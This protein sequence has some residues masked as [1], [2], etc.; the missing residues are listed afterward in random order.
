M[1]CFYKISRAADWKPNFNYCIQIT[2]A[3]T[4]SLTNYK[5]PNTNHLQRY[6]D[7]VPRLNWWLSDIVAVHL[8]IVTLFRSAI[9]ADSHHFWQ[10]SAV[11]VPKSVL[12]VSC[13]KEKC[14][15]KFDHASIRMLFD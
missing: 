2:V 15:R 12:V 6:Q 14:D 11:A 10:C 3:A 1:Q 8:E 7:N 4:L 5:M 9:F 13:I